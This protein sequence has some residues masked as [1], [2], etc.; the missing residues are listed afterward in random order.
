MKL[1]TQGKKSSIS[2]SQWKT[3][4]AF[5]SVA[6]GVLIGAVRGFF[7][8]RLAPSPQGQEAPSGASALKE[9]TA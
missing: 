1:T 9:R 2:V 3:S 7:M 8:T 4:F 6:M 5:F